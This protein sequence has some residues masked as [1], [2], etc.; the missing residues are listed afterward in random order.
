MPLQ[1]D[2]SICS[3]VG[4]IISDLL[5]STGIRG[6]KKMLGLNEVLSLTSGQGASAYRVGHL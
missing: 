4:I 5:V 1:F 2:R 6:L 3:E